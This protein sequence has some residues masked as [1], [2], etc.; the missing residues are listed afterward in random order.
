MDQQTSSASRSWVSKVIVLIL[1][2]AAGGLAFLFGKK[3]EDSEMFEEPS[4]SGNVVD[5]KTPAAAP[6]EVVAADVTYKDGVYSAIGDYNSPA[7]LETIDV[8]L[9]VADGVVTD[10][11]V[12]ANAT[13]PGSKM[14]QGKFIEG[15]KEQV[16]GKKLS[17]LSL[18]KVSGSSLTPKGFN[19]ALVEIRTEA[20]A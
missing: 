14:W 2:I 13:N 19:E 11:T 15:Y 17:D 3:A 9:T 5:T 20:Q 4:E 12:D 8:T 6:T 1:V 7:G 18:T 10:A 16:I